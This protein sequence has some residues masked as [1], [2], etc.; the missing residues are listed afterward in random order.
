MLKELELRQ[1]VWFDPFTRFVAGPETIAEGLDHVVGCDGNVG[2][3]SYVFA[4]KGHNP[5]IVFRGGSDVTRHI[6]YFSPVYPYMRVG[7]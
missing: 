4:P 5:L 1:Q 2:S 3:R 7:V 6:Q